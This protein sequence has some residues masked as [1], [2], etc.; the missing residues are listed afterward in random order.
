MN[1]ALQAVFAT[2]ENLDPSRIDIV[3]YA[4]CLND[5]FYFSLSVKLR[6][7]MYIERVWNTLF[8]IHKSREVRHR[9][10]DCYLRTDFL[11]LDRFT[12]SVA[13]DGQHPQYHGNRVQLTRYYHQRLVSYDF[14]G[15]KLLVSFECDGH[16][17]NEGAQKNAGHK[18]PAT[19]VE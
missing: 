10:D 9:I 13:G 15:T 1:G 17:T 16:L 6:Y 8:I 11:F 4:S 2:N 19:L 14:M 12:A 5:L 18:I 3:T 7:M